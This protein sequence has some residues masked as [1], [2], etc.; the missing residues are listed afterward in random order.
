MNGGMDGRGRGKTWQGDFGEWV[1][2]ESGCW[3]T[4]VDGVEEDLGGWV[5]SVKNDTDMKTPTLP[6]ANA[7][8]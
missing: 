6:P 7:S 3:W 5:G 8:L 1:F 4:L 2:L